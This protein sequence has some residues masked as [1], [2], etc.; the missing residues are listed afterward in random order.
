MFAASKTLFVT[1]VLVFATRT[2]G[3]ITTTAASASLTAAPSNPTIPPS[4]TA[5]AFQ[6]CWQSTVVGG[7]PASMPVDPLSVSAVGGVCV[8][9]T[10]TDAQGNVLFQTTTFPA[11]GA[12]SPPSGASA[13]SSKSDHGKK[14]IL[15][16]VLG[17]IFGL[18]LIVGGLVWL[19]FS[20]RAKRRNADTKEKRWAQMNFDKDADTLSHNDIE[21]GVAAQAN[22]VPARSDSLPVS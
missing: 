16:A 18:A 14:V 8:R 4:T 3:Q 20:R 13:L 10:S 22:A 21:K 12:S 11:P 9:P 19:A 17:S 7:A 1:L 2:M 5:P 6:D 15:P